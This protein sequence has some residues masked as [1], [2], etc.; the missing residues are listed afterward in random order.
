MGGLRAERRRIGPDAPGH[1]GDHP[2]RDHAHR[3]HGARDTDDR[4][5]RCRVDCEAGPGRRRWR[6]RQQDAGSAQ[7][8]RDCTSQAQVVRASQARTSAHP[9]GDEHSGRYFHCRA[10]GV[11][12][13]DN[14]AHRRTGPGARRRRRHRHG[15]GRGSGNRTGDGSWHRRGFRRG[16][17]SRGQRRLVAAE[18]SERSSRTTPAR[19]CA[20]ASRAWSRWRPS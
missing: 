10:A 17:L 11:H 13:A 16:H 12:D 3:C 5:A 14:R 9:A 15:F 18:S 20:P 8:S 7:K 6:R 2:L 1:P 4:P 19:R